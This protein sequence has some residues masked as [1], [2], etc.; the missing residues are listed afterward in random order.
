MIIYESYTRLGACD[1]VEC[2]RSHRVEQMRM[3]GWG[4][5]DDIHDNSR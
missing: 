3:I 2:E 1:R 4:E 5:S